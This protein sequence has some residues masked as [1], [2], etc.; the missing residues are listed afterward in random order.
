M[1]GGVLANGEIGRLIGLVSR[2][3]GLGPRS[4]RRIVLALLRDPKG[5][6]VPLARAMQEAA[7]SVR[8]CSRC[9]NLDGKDPCHICMDPSRQQDVVCVVE[10]VADLWALERAG[11]YHGVYMVLGGVLSALSGVGPDDLN[12]RP[13]LTRLDEGSVRE[14]ILALSATVDGATTMHWLQERL[15]GYGV[16][17]TRVAQGVPVGGALEVLDDGTLAAAL[18]AR[19]PVV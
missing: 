16:S 5:R 12:L 4:A 13:L 11:T 3:P 15:G 8:T 10:S 2:L 9:G 19:R 18:S 6:M 17:I 1:A 14:V 7:A